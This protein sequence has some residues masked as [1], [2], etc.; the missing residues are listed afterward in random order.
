MV[1]LCERLVFRPAWDQLQL[2]T[3]RHKDKV[4]PG[5]VYLL[6]SNDRLKCRVELSPLLNLPPGTEVA[7]EKED[8]LAI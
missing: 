2:I 4:C 3:L 5:Y 7:I 1:S 8:W 6:G